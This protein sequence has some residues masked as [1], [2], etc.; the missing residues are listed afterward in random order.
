[1]DPVRRLRFSV[2]TLIPVIAFG[3]PDYAMSNDRR[4]FDPL[5]RI[6]I[7]LAMVVFRKVHALGPESR[8]I[9][10]PRSE[11]NFASNPELIILNKRPAISRLEA[12]AGGN[13]S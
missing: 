3:P 10:N 2:A 6:I 9:F 7:I 13:P 8:M 12:I 1:M 5:Y 4:A 11:K